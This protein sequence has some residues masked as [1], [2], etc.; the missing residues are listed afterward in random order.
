MCHTLSTI[1]VCVCVLQKGGVASGD[2][3][4]GLPFLLQY[5]IFPYEYGDG[6]QARSELWVEPQHGVITGYPPG[7]QYLA[8]LSHTHI[9]EAVSGW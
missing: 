1:I 2:E 9:A 3:G 6:Q 5:V 8:G 4:E 7:V